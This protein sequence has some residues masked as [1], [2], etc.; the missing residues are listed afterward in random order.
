M[1]LKLLVGNYDGRSFLR[2]LIKI[3]LR[4]ND[5]WDSYC[6]P[7]LH[8]ASLFCGGQPDIIDIF[9]FDPEN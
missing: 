6:F 9:F 2:K 4:S 8:H 1:V 5:D 7:R 3:F